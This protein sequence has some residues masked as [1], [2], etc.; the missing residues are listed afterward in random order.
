MVTILQRKIQ[1]VIKNLDNIDLDMG[2]APIVFFDWMPHTLTREIIEPGGVFPLD[3]YYGQHDDHSRKTG[4]KRLRFS[5]I[6]D[7][8]DMR[9]GKKE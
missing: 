8:K 5:V 2:Y 6:H 4:C 3:L 1:M 7:N 9:W